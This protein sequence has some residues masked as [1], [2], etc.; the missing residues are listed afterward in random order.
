MIPIP[1]T[2]V[3]VVA[4]AALGFALS[5][6]PAA[7]AASPVVL[8]CLLPPGVYGITDSSGALVGLLIVYPDC[9]MEVYPRQNEA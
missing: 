1:R 9:R 2:I 5:V 8:S 3:R 4:A 6:A 7:A